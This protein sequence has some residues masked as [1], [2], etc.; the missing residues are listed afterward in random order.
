M[1]KFTRCSRSVPV[2]AAVVPQILDE[3]GQVRDVLEL[4]I[5][6]RPPE[7]GGDLTLDRRHDGGARFV[8]RL[9]V[10]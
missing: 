3:P 5:T 4:R 10:V 6:W 9:P 8:L 7:V 2:A 1:T